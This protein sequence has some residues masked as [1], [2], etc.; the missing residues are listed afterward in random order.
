M[1]A[2][3]QAERD[4]STATPDQGTGYLEAAELITKLVTA[5]ERT[6]DQAVNQ[7]QEAIDAQAQQLQAWG[8][9]R[10]IRTV[11]RTQ[12]GESGTR[13]K[14]RVGPLYP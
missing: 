11:L 1:E 7:Q 9:D 12:A 6:H 4:D 3:T 2:Q 13:R 10:T 5:L 14:R 8:I